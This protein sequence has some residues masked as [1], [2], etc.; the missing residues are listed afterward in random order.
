MTKR[1]DLD[2]EPPLFS[3]N[4]LIDKGWLARMDSNHE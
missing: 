4:S 2:S 3:R 1:H